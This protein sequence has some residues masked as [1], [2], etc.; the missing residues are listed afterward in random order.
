VHLE[1]DDR[2]YF[3]AGAAK[4]VLYDARPPSPTHGLVQE[5]FL[6]AADGALVRIPAGVFHA[7][8]NVG[9]SEL[10]YVNMPTR[11]YRHELPDKYR[12]PA[13]TSFIPYSL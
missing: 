11:A 2:I 9:P 10:R 8:V 4:V 3:G 13:D 12:L 5:L 6:G 7:V 1:Q